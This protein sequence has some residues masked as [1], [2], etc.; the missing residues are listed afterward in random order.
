MSV[1]ISGLHK[2]ELL[3]HLVFHTAPTGLGWIEFGRGFDIVE[4][5]SMAE[6][7]FVDYCR[8]R[9]IKTDLR[10]MLANPRLYD[11][12][13]G[14]GEFQKVVNNLRFLVG[15]FVTRIDEV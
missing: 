7:G 14:A 12:D 9:C 5:T 8:G 13:A 11:R 1:N 2:G 10:G 15:V 3:Q 4:A 6:G